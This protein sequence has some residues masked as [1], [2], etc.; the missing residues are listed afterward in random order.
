MM[1]AA[2]GNRSSSSFP[3]IPEP[4]EEAASG[5]EA[6]GVGQ[7]LPGQIDANHRIAAVL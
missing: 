5:V 3:L 6:S 1:R 4:L 7:H 2:S